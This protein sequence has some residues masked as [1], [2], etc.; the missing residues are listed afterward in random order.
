MILVPE[1]TEAEKNLLPEVKG[2]EGVFRNICN[3]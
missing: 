1:N 2:A 3:V